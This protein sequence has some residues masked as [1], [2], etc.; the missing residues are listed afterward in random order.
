MEIR[1]KL[2]IVRQICLGLDYAHRHQIY[3]RDIKPANIKILHDGT[4][5]IMDFGLATMQTSG[6]TKTGTIMGTPHYMS[7]EMV[8]G[9]KVDGRSD[10]FA[11]GVILYEFLTYNKPFTGDN[12]ST[13]L[14][15][16]ISEEPKAFD[17][18]VTSK[19]PELGRIVEKALQKDIN[20]RYQNMKL[21]AE[22]IAKLQHKIVTQDFKM[23]DAT[24]VI[25]ESMET[26]LMD[27]ELDYSVDIKPEKK[28]SQ[29]PLIITGFLIIA[30][31][32]LYF[33]VLKKP[34]AG[35]AEAS[36]MLTF[37]VKPY[38]VIQGIENIDSKIKINLSEAQKTSPSQIVLN[39][40][41]Y[42]ITYTHPSWKSEKRSREIEV[43]PGS[44]TSLV[45]SI[46]VSF[47]EEA[48]EHFKVR[49]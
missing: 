28:K 9:T 10:Q 3:H 13:I 15:K 6:L 11:V 43:K 25:D 5:K 14:Y 44:T 33:M 31:I 40:G 20:K 35:S 30:A 24:V 49:K 4:I 29:L 45:D 46:S 17:P 2:E 1:D 38:A 12:I 36:G 22:D 42:R 48:V 34:D 18:K 41:R 47:I 32:V 26:V 37:N 19:Y 27:T 23:T 16:I 7:P 39:P 8:N 21:M